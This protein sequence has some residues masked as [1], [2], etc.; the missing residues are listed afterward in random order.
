MRPT[1]SSAGRDLERRVAAIFRSLGASAEHDVSLA[2]SQVDVVVREASAAG[3]TITTMIE[4]KAYARP[5]GI[6]AIVAL[7][8]ISY[9][10]KQRKL[11]DR[12]MIVS[13]NGF[14]RQ[15]RDSAKEHNIDLVELGDLEQKVAGARVQFEKEVESHIEDVK[16]TKAKTP[17]LHAFV[18][19][20]F[21]REFDD[22]YILGIREVAERMD[23]VVERADSIEHNEEII[24]IVREKIRHC[25]VIVADTT[26]KNPNVFYEIGYAHALEKPT[27]LITRKG[28]QIP[29]DVRSINHIIYESIVELRDKLEKR[30]RG[31]ILSS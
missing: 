7:A 12:A 5:V 21:S 30:I 19:M 20:P 26:G 8:S 4:C 9:L 28:D 10:L 31:T 17:R 23:F 25:D 2:G 13:T 14:T 22:V 15:A 11:I 24:D 16:N 18:L 27:I 6:E 1:P 3:K 29:F